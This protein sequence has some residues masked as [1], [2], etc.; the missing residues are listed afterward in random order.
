MFGFP[1]QRKDIANSPVPAKKVV[2][3]MVGDYGRTK[4]ATLEAEM[5]RLE[6]RRVE[7][8]QRL[9]RYQSLQD[10]RKSEVEWE[11]E[12]HLCDEIVNNQE[13]AR[14]MLA[15]IKRYDEDRATGWQAKLVTENRVVDVV[16]RRKLDAEL[17]R[18]SA[19]TKASE[20]IKHVLGLKDMPMLIAKGEK[21]Y[22]HAKHLPKNIAYVRVT[23]TEDI[24]TTRSY[25]A[26]ALEREE[27]RYGAI[28]E[29]DVPE[30][31]GEKDTSEQAVFNVKRDVFSV[32]YF[33]HAKLLPLEEKCAFVKKTDFRAA[34]QAFCYSHRRARTY[35]EGDRFV[36][37]LNT[38]FN[39]YLG[40][41]NLHRAFVACNLLGKFAQNK[42]ACLEEVTQLFYQ[43]DVTKLR[44]L[45]D[46]FL[47][48]VRPGGSFYNLL[49]AIAF[50]KET[51]EK[52]YLDSMTTHK[53]KQ[54]AIEK[55]QKEMRSS[56]N[57]QIQANK[58]IQLQQEMDGLVAEGCAKKRALM[59]LILLG[60]LLWGTFDR[61]QMAL[62]RMGHACETVARPEALT[63]M[64]QVKWLNRRFLRGFIDA[65]SAP[66]IAA[67]MPVISPRSDLP[68][69]STVVPEPLPAANSTVTRCVPA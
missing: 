67:A 9:L 33:T 1:Q 69:F 58:I 64:Q 28:Y 17:R 24:K 27:E 25:V 65:A 15:E 35:T 60:E 59:Q 4:I 53:E 21:G 63:S 34:L 38:A 2:L 50:Y 19:E 29:A 32:Q 52:E 3:E 62:R 8:V 26:K 13:V 11:F 54:Q 46:H 31:V 12:I 44:R 57:P 18:R 36:D 48:D 22:E 43:T 10:E 14:Q 51:L 20:A 47:R 61:L 49:A 7:L 42:Q 23:H 66:A 5:I 41:K 55:L 37:Q 40:P 16:K 56:Q 45:H 6:Q 30:M 68:R 39:R